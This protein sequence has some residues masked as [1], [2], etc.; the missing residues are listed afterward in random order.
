MKALQENVDVA[1]NNRVVH[2]QCLACGHAWV[3]YDGQR[4][5]CV[6]CASDKLSRP[7]SLSRIREV[8]E[9]AQKQVATGQLT[10]NDLEA[11]K[12][13]LLRDYT[14]AAPVFAQRADET[15][16]K[17]SARYLDGDLSDR[18]LDALVFCFHLFTELGLHDAAV[19]CALL[20]GS[21]HFRR[22]QDKDIRTLN[23]LADLAA[24]RQWFAHLGQHE[25][26]A[27]VDLLTGLKAGHT[28]L[29]HVRDKYLLLQISRVHLHRARQYY[30][31]QNFPEI[32]QRVE[33][34]C[35]WINDQLSHAINA[36]AQIEAAQINASSHIDA[37]RIIKAG[38]DD[39]GGSI[40]S[41]LRQLAISVENGLDSLGQ[42]IDLAGGRV[43][44]AIAAGSVYIGDQTRAAGYMIGTGIVEHA[45]QMREGMKELGKEVGESVKAAGDKT[46]SA[47]SG[48]GTKV[49]LG[50]VGAG[51]LHALIMD[52]TLK[53]L[54][55]T[56][57]P[58]I[59]QGLD[60]LKLIDTATPQPVRV[61][62]MQDVL[63]SRGLD[64]LNSRSRAFG[65]PQLAVVDAN[66]KGR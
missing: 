33:K 56:V 6:L 24:A 15:F 60:N 19:R 13:I 22:V 4:T 44:T 59:R 41:G 29:E 64:E 62:D 30:A 40:F 17:I 37:A 25:W 58:Q 1:L 16:P 51:A 36:A 46:A 11:R 53:E 5:A 9:Q 28:V 57:T 63:I 32:Q 31:G 43:S 38:L 48:L 49:A 65:L 8:T 23:D 20:I 10:A 18:C 61:R 26:V 50:V 34:E 14:R 2:Q 35:D 39:L 54:A 12:A 52:G 21:G 47:M 27:T 7:I 45:K 3:D 42:R 66:Q 55:G